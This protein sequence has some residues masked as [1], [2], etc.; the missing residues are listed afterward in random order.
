MRQQGTV[1]VSFTIDRNGRVL[2][3]RIVASS[4]H[5]ALDREVSAMLRRASPFPRIP[6]GFGQ[7]RLSVTVPIRFAL[8]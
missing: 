7:S 8:R 6:S 1:R 3:H 5:T 4:G 2:S